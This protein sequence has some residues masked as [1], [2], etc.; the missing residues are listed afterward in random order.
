MDASNPIFVSDRMTFGEMINQSHT[1]KRQDYRKLQEIVENGQRIS[2]PY[3]EN[4]PIKEVQPDLIKTLTV[5]ANKPVRN[6]KIKLEKLEI[7]KKIQLNE[8]PARVFKPTIRDKATLVY[9]LGRVPDLVKEIDSLAYTT[10]TKEGFEAKLNEWAMQK[11]VSSAKIC[12]ENALNIKELIRKRFPVRALQK[13]TAHEFQDLLQDVKV[14]KNSSAGPPYFRPK[15]EVWETVVTELGEIIDAFTS[16]NQN[17]FLSE[18]P[19]L[20]ASECKNKTD[21]YRVSQMMEKTR[22]YWSQNASMQILYAF[23]SQKFTEALKLFTES[24]NSWNG[25]GFSYAHGGGSKLADW[26]LTTEPGEVKCAIYGDDVKM[27]WREKDGTLWNVNPD[28]R[29]MDASVDRATVTA[30]VEYIVESFTKQHG[31]SPFW[32]SISKLWIESAINSDFWI[33]GIQMHGKEGSLRT[34]VVGTTFFDTVKSM[35]VYEVLLQ[36]RVNK[37][38]EKAVAKTF[39]EMGMQLKEGTWNPS[40]VNESPGV[41]EF[42]FQEKWLGAHLKMEYGSKYTEPI[43]FVAEEDVAKLMGNPRHTVFAATSRT[44]R[45]RY[46]FDSARGYMFLTMH[47]ENKR[48]WNCCCDVIENTDADVITQAVQAGGGKGEKPEL[49][50]LTGEDFEWPS[51]DGVPSRE[52]CLDVFLSEDNKLGGVWIDLFPTLGEELKRFRK[53]RQKASI[54]TMNMELNKSWADQV[55]VKE[56]QDNA[57]KFMERAP[58]PPPAFAEEPPLNKKVVINSGAVY[59]RTQTEEERRKR[60]ELF[61]GEDLYDAI[62]LDYVFGVFQDNGKQF[63]YKT[64]RDL[65]WYPHPKRVLKQIPVERVSK[66]DYGD[67]FYLME[68]F[69]KDFDVPTKI[70]PISLQP[71][72]FSLRDIAKRIKNLKCN[73]MDPISIVSGAFNEAGLPLKS[74]NTVLSNSPENVVEHK[75]WTVEGGFER[76]MTGTSGVEAR[77]RLF[78]TILNDMLELNLKEENKLKEKVEEKEREEDFK[79]SKITDDDYDNRD[80]AGP[81][82]EED[83]PKN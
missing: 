72:G 24:K 64:V 83:N 62:S 63:V 36:K 60:I 79:I 81:S 43:P 58:T 13:W 75:I 15:T 23:L 42:L 39:T 80:G 5:S 82:T 48:L 1:L 33:D 51:S 67:I 17:A 76:S 54:V 19:Y 8:Y 71:S 55:L 16:G 66:V 20:L 25:Y 74:K 4:E 49:V 14:T 18:R 28:F 73:K 7:K 61:L 47:K 22:P 44:A 9:L 78:S 12:K 29:A 40:I 3:F 37:F 41:G 11:P 70:P 32:E 31:S 56:L 53:T 45:Q 10:G 30:A 6:G 21:R 77:K 34:G 26:A 69:E 46:M 50:A 68:E 38:D 57:E 27:V 65:G 35:I 2:A 59:K 52:F